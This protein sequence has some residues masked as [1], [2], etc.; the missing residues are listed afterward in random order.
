MKMA[1][2][3]AA[4]LFAAVRTTEWLNVLRGPMALK[5]LERL[6]SARRLTAPPQGWFVNVCIA[7]L[8]VLCA[9]FVIVTVHRIIKELKSSAQL[10]AKYANRR[11]LSERER[12]LLRAIAKL[13]HLK[14]SES[15]FTMGK[16]FD[17][18]S[19]AMIERVHSRQDAAARASLKQELAELRAKIGY[20]GS[21]SLETDSATKQGTKQILERKKLFITRRHGERLT[22]IEPL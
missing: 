1:I 13:A 12:Q 18:G 6:Q 7:A 4:R 5:P 3:I 21:G 14:R 20:H 22:D 15:I 19:A 17:H 2:V 10:F 8:V 11:G 16:A 9:V